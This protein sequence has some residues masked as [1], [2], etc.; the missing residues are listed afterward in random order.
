[1]ADST[2]TQL[3]NLLGQYMGAAGEAGAEISRRNLQLWNDVSESLRG[4]D[5]QL[6]QAKA[7]AL[8]VARAVA[9]NSAD[10]WR[11]ATTNPG[12]ERVA[13]PLPLAFLL[14]TPKDP[15]SAPPWDCVPPDG[16]WV[17]LPRD[18][19]AEPAQAR[20]EIE[21]GP[22]VARM[23]DT[24]TVE[25]RAGFGYYIGTRDA[26]PLAPGAYAGGVY[27]SD[28]GRPLAQLRVEVRR[29]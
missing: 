14:F 1:M 22:D 11:L 4:G 7:D 10:L 28:T 19:A 9:A 26:G 5:Y 8:R 18:V 12:R 15:D 21:S 6:E 20:I 2:R 13:A 17:R 3:W 29:L 27:A 24:L 25:P 23:G 16:A